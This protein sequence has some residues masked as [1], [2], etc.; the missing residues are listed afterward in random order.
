MFKNYFE[1][2]K[3]R[4]GITILFCQLIIIMVQLATL[5]QKT[6]IIC[7]QHPYEDA[8]VCMEQ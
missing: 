8:I 3:K 4:A 7:K 6:M 5:N 2:F 1:G